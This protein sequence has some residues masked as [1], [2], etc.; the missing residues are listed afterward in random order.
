MTTDEKLDKVIEL[1]LRI[2]KN[3]TKFLD[4]GRPGVRPNPDTKPK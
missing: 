2:D 3:L 1:L 4:R